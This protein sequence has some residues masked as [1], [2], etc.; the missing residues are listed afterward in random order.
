[1]VLKDLNPASGCEWVLPLEPSDEMAALGHTGSQPVT[2]PEA[3]DPAG[4]HRVLT[5]DT[6][7]EQMPLGAAKFGG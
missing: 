5:T 2:A 6:G 4:L 3:G 7:R 1:M